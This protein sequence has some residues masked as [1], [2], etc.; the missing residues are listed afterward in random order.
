MPETLDTLIKQSFE[1]D[2][3]KLGD[4]TTQALF[5]ENVVGE[6]SF[7]CKANGVL[8]GTMVAKRCFQLYDRTAV[9]K[10]LEADGDL[11]NKGQEIAK[12]KGTI[13]TL[14]AVE[15]TALNFLSHLSGIATTTKSF[16]D[17]LEGTK[18]RIKD[19]R[20][21]TP[22]LRLLEKE[23]VLHGGG[24]NHRS[25]LYDGVLIKDNHLASRSVTQAVSQAREN[26]KGKLIEVE[27]ENMEQVK[28]ALNAQADILLLDNMDTKSINEAVE[29]INGKVKIEASGGV[30]IGTAREIAQTGVDFISTSAI[31]MA[32]IPLD[33]T[34]EI[35][36]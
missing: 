35:K 4:I 24:L 19:T 12:V 11:V 29:F 22:G 27:V 34:F 30:M 1:E 17:Q 13:R 3:S 6:G 7:I 18:C 23:A 2:L 28:E 15:R 16:V 33:M 8:S 21:T 26:I 32:A 10:A 36:K 5:D 20:K 25:G 31:I 14:L 9:F